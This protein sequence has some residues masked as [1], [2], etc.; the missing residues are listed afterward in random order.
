[1]LAVLIK[2]KFSALWLF[3]MSNMA[4]FFLQPL[5]ATIFS[6]KGCKF[7]TFCDWLQF[8]SF[9]LHGNTNN[10]PFFLFIQNDFV[11]LPA[12]TKNNSN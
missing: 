10:F 6:L 9:F 4:Q 3:A 7:L 12:L 8:L 5:G 1:M 11:S 2:Q